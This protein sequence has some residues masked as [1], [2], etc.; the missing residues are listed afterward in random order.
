MKVAKRICDS[1][2]L[3]LV[4]SGYA[5]DFVHVKIKRIQPGKF[6]VKAWQRIPLPTLVVHRG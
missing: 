4:V 6:E 5:A 1:N 2:N 3:S